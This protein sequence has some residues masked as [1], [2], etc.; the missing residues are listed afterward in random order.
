MSEPEPAP[1]AETFPTIDELRELGK[2]QFTEGKYEEAKETYTKAIR[3]SKES[4]EQEILYNNRA[5]SSFKLKCWED[6]EA[7]CTEA[8]IANG[9]KRTNPKSWF[10]RGLC[11]M[12][13]KR[14]IEAECDLFMAKTLSPSDSDISKKYTDCER[15]LDASTNLPSGSG[16]ISHKGR[17]LR[18]KC[19]F[20]MRWSLEK[21]YHLVAACDMRRGTIIC[22][23]D[24]FAFVNIIVSAQ[25]EK[26]DSS[27]DGF[28]WDMNIP[29]SD[30]EWQL[31]QQIV[32]KFDGDRQKV[33]RILADYSVSWNSVRKTEL[34][35]SEALAYVTM[36]FQEKGFSSSLL[37]F[38]FGIMGSNC[39]WLTNTTSL[40]GT[41]YGFGFYKQISR[42][43]HSCTPNC[44]INYAGKVA[45][46]TVKGEATSDYGDEGKGESVHV[47]KD[48]K[49]TTI[50]PEKENIDR[51][52]IKEGTELTISYR[53]SWSG[54]SEDVRAL[55][56]FKQC[57]FLCH[58]QSCTTPRVRVKDA[59]QIAA[60]KAEQ[61]ARELDKQAKEEEKEQ[62]KKEG[63]TSEEEKPK[64]SDDPITPFNLKQVESS[65]IPIIYQ[66]VFDKYAQL[67]EKDLPEPIP[68]SE[69]DMVIRRLNECFNKKEWQRLFELCTAVRA[70]GEQKTHP[71][72]V[73]VDKNLVLPSS[74]LPGHVANYV[75]KAACLSWMNVRQSSSTAVLPETAL[76]P[77]VLNDQD[78]KI[79]HTPSFSD[80][81]LGRYVHTQIVRT[82]NSSALT[83]F[84]TVFP[85]LD[86]MSRSRWA[87]WNEA[88]LDQS[89]RTELNSA[90]LMRALVDGRSEKASVP[91]CCHVE[92]VAV[93]D[94]PENKTTDS[95]KTTIQYS[96]QSVWSEWSEDISLGEV[97]EKELT[98]LRQMVSNPELSLLSLFIIDLIKFLFIKLESA[99]V[100]MNSHTGASLGYGFVRFFSPESSL[101][102]IRN[103][104][105][106]RIENKV[107]LVKT[108]HGLKEREKIP[109]NYTV[110]IRRIP[111][112]VT[113][114]FLISRMQK[115]GIVEQA[116]LLADHFDP[117]RANKIAYVRFSTILSAAEC[118]SKE[119]GSMYLDSN[120]PIEVEYA[121]KDLT[122]RHT[123][124][125]RNSSKSFEFSSP[126]ASFLPKRREVI[127]VAIQPNRTPQLFPQ[128]LQAYTTPH[129][130]P[131]ITSQ[132][133]QKLNENSP[134]IPPIRWNIVHEKPVPLAQ[135]I[136]P[137]ST[138]TNQ[139]STPETQGLVSTP[140][141]KLP[142]S[143]NQTPTSLELGSVRL[144]SIPSSHS[145]HSFGSS[146]LP[147]TI[148]SPPIVFPQTTLAEP[149][150]FSR[151]DF[152]FPSHEFSS[153]FTTSD[154]TFG[155][156]PINRT[157]FDC[158]FSSVSGLDHHR[159]EDAYD[160]LFVN[161]LSHW[162]PVS[163]SDSYRL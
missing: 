42:L 60:E 12:E 86:G 43:N 8:M 63:K 122:I 26:K 123:H 139:A 2:Q 72:P 115:Y 17:N 117:D 137:T 118:V 159:S 67:E 128:T 151:T 74:S 101:N 140:P 125:N 127:P 132:P 25:N 102:A 52:W 16:F 57:G 14:F 1:S 19:G 113:Q 28:D 58:C 45:V 22:A 120:V 24:A 5:L 95:A 88:I 54:Y 130:F 155:S 150:L 40:N 104:N 136:N 107:L 48:G 141:H 38:L 83:L 110:L 105:K 135:T 46:L 78:P 84:S 146:D 21:G 92:E 161:S 109:E 131:V 9:E 7:D 89:L 59:W 37:S 44:E 33:C 65:T 76:A 53:P 13:Q 129:Q 134:A 157:D 31:V 75:A 138:Q 35:Q 100:M 80:E 152:Q 34:E 15:R 47:G 94:N 11:R 51:N 49:T 71:S 4:T 36:K 32:N 77:L 163:H 82:Q 106:F 56:M 90:L 73:T 85:L 10:R 162:P 160:P 97:S 91:L 98:Q 23:E 3:I 99:R 112:S 29:S 147:I 61:E 158:I 142:I 124:R 66:S 154:V 149:I 50:K 87:L 6:C 96:V 111:S 133:S 79:T 126:E 144:S 153:T 18:N 148:S 64:P 27:T 69:W 20:R 93:A 119:T 39:L 68:S 143:L 30:P 121:R 103:L 62:D 116:H 70:Y 156:S 145:D 81:I 41:P 114:S 55:T 108:S